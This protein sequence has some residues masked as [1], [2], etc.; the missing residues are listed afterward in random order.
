MGMSGRRGGSPGDADLP[1]SPLQV[2]R[3]H[4]LVADRGHEEGVRKVVAELEKRGWTE[5]L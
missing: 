3:L 2:R 5:Y 1:L 4:Q